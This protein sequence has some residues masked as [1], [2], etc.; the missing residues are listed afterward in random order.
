VIS[1]DIQFFFNIWSPLTCGTF[2]STPYP[3]ST[4]IVTQLVLAKTKQF[5][6]R[7]AIFFM[8]VGTILILLHLFLFT[9]VG[10]Q[11]GLDV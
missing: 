7:Q 5:W 3:L 9:W 10:S 8:Y 6:S 2:H 4:R 1:G 11:G